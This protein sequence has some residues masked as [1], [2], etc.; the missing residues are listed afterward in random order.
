VLSNETVDLTGLLVLGGLVD[1]H[2]LG[3]AW[4]LGPAAEPLGVLCV[5]TVE[6]GLAPARISIAVPKWTEAGVCIPIP[7]WRCSW[8]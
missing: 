4:R 8:L 3:Q 1:P 2:L 5:G 6:G 7:E